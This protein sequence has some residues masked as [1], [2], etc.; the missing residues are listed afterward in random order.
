MWT[1]REVRVALP[2]RSAVTL[3]ARARLVEHRQRALEERRTASTSVLQIDTTAWYELPR[4]PWNPKHA[5]VFAYNAGPWMDAGIGRGPGLCRLQ[6]HSLPITSIVGALTGPEEAL[7]RHWSDTI[8]VVGCCRYSERGCPAL[9]R[10]GT[11]PP[12]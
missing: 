2:P 1:S 12:P 8:G 4:T 3:T 7:S 9:L 6:A 11:E 10:T 5:S